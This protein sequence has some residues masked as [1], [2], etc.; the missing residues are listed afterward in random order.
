MKTKRILVLVVLP[1][2]LKLILA[3]LIPGHIAVTAD[4][5]GDINTLQRISDLQLEG[6]NP[7]SVVE[8]RR[9]LIY[10]PAFYA[11]SWFNGWLQQ[12]TGL[13][14]YFIIKILPILAESVMALLLFSLLSKRYDGKKALLWSALFVYNPLLFAIS[15]IHGQFDAIVLLAMLLAYYWFTTL[16]GAK[17][18]AL[19]S[20]ALGIGASFKYY[21]LILGPVFF[22]AFKSVRDRVL[23]PIIT[24]GSYLLSYLPFAFGPYLSVALTQPFQFT[25]QSNWGIAKL[26]VALAY[27]GR[28]VSGLNSFFQAWGRVILAIGLIAAALIFSKQE[29]LG[30]SIRMMFYA[31]Y[32]VSVFIHPQYLLWILPFLFLAIRKETVIF[33]FL[34]GAHIYFL[35]IFELIGWGLGLPPMPPLFGAFSFLFGVLTWL[36]CAWMLISSLAQDGKR[37]EYRRMFS[38]AY[39]LKG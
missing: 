2:I 21:P 7:Y 32:T 22:L 24:L 5:R 15:A 27:L 25:P 3:F 14:Y 29:S 1:I 17:R 8:L 13:P 23:F 37:I 19:V 39:W 30:K 36:F 12:M 28:D 35:Y 10:G 34:A 11:L 31:L 4:G 6:K 38:V 20:L 18:V 16:E 9:N 33:S 26:Q